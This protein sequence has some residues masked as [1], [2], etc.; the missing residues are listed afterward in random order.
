MR[1]VRRVVLAFAAVIALL[2]LGI[3]AV[4]LFAVHQESEALDQVGVRAPVLEVDGLRVRDRNKNG[5]IDP[6]EDPRVPVDERTED[7][8]GRMTVPE[9]VGL[10]LQPPILMEESG[11]LVDGWGSAFL[12]GFGTAEAILVR[13][14][15]HFNLM[16]ASTCRAMA[17]WHNSVQQLAER[18]RLGIPV[19]ISTDPRHGVRDTGRATAVRTEG[20][21][22]WP[23]PIGLAAT[24]DEALVKR[25]GEIANQEYRAV[26]LRTALHPMADLAT[27]PRWGRIVGTFGSDAGLASKMVTAYVEGFQGPAIG[28]ES[29]LCMTK[30]FP[31][32]GPQEDG[33]DAHFSYGANQA[34][35][36][37][38]FEY[39]L[40]PFEA[41]ISAGT[42]Q[43]MP[44]YGVPVGQTSEEVAMSFNRD[45]ITGLL[46]NR[47]GFDGVVCTDWQIVVPRR[48]GPLEWMHARNFGVEDLSIP[49]RYAKALEAGVDQFGGEDDPEPLIALV[50]SGKLTTER[51][52]VS[53]RRIL[54]DKFRLGLFE[55]PYVDADAADDICD[56]PAFREAG[57]EAQRQSIVLLQNEPGPDGQP[58]LPLSRGTRIWVEN[59]DASVAARYGTVVPTLEEADVALVRAAAPHVPHPP[60]TIGDRIFN[61]IFHQG[62]LDFKDDALDHLRSIGRTKPTVLALYLDRP[63]VLSGVVDHTTGILAHFGATD[64]ALLDV[65]FGRAEPR[66]KLPVELPASMDAVRAQKED[67]PDDSESPLFPFGFGL[68]YEDRGG[69]P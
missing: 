1:I 31:G 26:G 45:I 51:L 43:M 42:A 55:D 50:G 44:Y 60:E 39:H 8:L 16:N 9:K 58:I 33:L 54:R 52:D 19:T 68:K 21:S 59:V 20:F 14:I 6:Y 15:R 56:Q 64:E 11:R 32:G 22:Q 7:L 46:R 17:E 67:L 63:A 41:A 37:D 5:T 34:Y 38:N 36:G 57:E 13:Q 18:T 3:T 49:E 62:D 69:A 2:L 10:M 35:P 28:T 66:G 61:T 47:F 12:P 65:A 29:V 53:I 30:H 27:E 48:L 4:V 40:L 25:F 23:E 24:R